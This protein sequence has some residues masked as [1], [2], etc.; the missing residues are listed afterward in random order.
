MQEEILKY[1]ETAAVSRKQLIANGFMLLVVF[2]W[3]SS[4]VSIKIAVGEIPPITMAFI[5]F[6]IASAFL[7]FFN[8]KS[9][10]RVSKKDVPFICLGGL[11]GITLYFFFENTG[12]KLSTAANASLIVMIVPMLTILLDVLFFKSALPRLK[13]AGLG[14]ATVGTYLSVTGNGLVQLDGQHFIGNVFILGAMVTWAL[15]TLINKRLQK[16]YSGLLL[17]TYQTVFGTLCLAPMAFTEQASWR[18][19]SV[20]AFGHI[21]F[22]A[23]C[24]SVLC[25]LLYLH[26]LKELDVVVTTLYLNLVPIIGVVSSYLVLGERVLPIQLLGGCITVLAILLINLEP[27]LLK[28]GNLKKKWKVI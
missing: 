26:V 27:F 14:I 4:F 13:L 21:L 3:G 18:V 19:F 9:A 10:D 16:Q 6:A 25:Y 15:Y 12:V 2:L 5:R 7:L 23:I 8:R 17:T 24:C 1:K 20:Q 11:F 22:L 28:A